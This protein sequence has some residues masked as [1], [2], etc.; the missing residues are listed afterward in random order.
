MILIKYIQRSQQKEKHILFKEI[1]SI[2][3]SVLHNLLTWFYNCKL[4]QPN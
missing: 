3:L 2:F 1:V 4:E